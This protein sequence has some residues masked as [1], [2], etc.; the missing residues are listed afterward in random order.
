MPTANSSRAGQGAPSC[1]SP[2]GPRRAPHRD[3]LSPALHQGQG[4]GLGQADGS[5]ARFDPQPCVWLQLM[6]FPGC[7]EV[8]GVGTRAESP[9]KCLRLLSGRGVS[10]L[11][12]WSWAP[13]G[14]P[15]PRVYFGLSAWSFW[16]SSAGS[17]P[18]VAD[19]SF[20][21]TKKP[22]ARPIT[23]CAEPLVK[24]F[25]HQGRALWC[26]PPPPPCHLLLLRPPLSSSSQPTVTS[27]QAAQ[28]EGCL[29]TRVS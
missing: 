25:A 15:H 14:Q 27:S 5:V 6:A 20:T 8:P 18:C 9:E 16:V 21:H 4:A 19:L 2:A 7:S 1:C 28:A 24:F 11:S 12:L 23:G 26:P 22:K 13:A 29:L 17:S 3:P 10:V